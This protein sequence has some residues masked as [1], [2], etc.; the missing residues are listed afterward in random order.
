MFFST[1][2]IQ[3]ITKSPRANLVLL[4]LATFLPALNARMTPRA[5]MFKLG[6]EEKKVVLIC[7]SRL[8]FVFSLCPLWIHDSTKSF[9][10]VCHPGF[11]IKSE[12]S[13]IQICPWLEASFSGIMQFYFSQTR[14]MTRLNFIVCTLREHACSNNSRKD[15]N[16][17][18]IKRPKL[19]PGRCSPFRHLL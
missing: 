14:P 3:K 5:T 19:P 18:Q 16:N 17:S 9:P 15:E 8:K 12:P 6:L 4:I 13:Q 7:Y 1:E 10:S 11:T 2:L